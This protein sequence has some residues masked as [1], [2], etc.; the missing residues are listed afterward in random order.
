[1]SV[2]IHSEVV[3]LDTL[4]PRPED[5]EREDKDVESLIPWV[6]RDSSIAEGDCGF[7]WPYEE[8]KFRGFFLSYSSYCCELSWS[9][10][11]VRNTLQ[12]SETITLPRLSWALPQREYFKHSLRSQ[13]L[14]LTTLLCNVYGSLDGIREQGPRIHFDPFGLKQTYVLG[15]KRFTGKS[16]G[17]ATTK[18]QSGSV[19]I[20]SCTGWYGSQTWNEFLTETL[21]IMLG[22]LAK[23]IFLPGDGAQVQDQEVYAVGFRGAYFHIVYGYFP[24][25]T[26]TRVHSKGCARDEKLTLRFSRGYHLNLKGDWRDAMRALARLFRYL[27]SGEAEVGA[28]KAYGRRFRH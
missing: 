16:E 15:G 5:T 19:P 21:S 23:N 20:I 10:T 11:A 6:F 22:Q 25:G 4:I 26:I 12:T 3:D 18:L 13:G 8:H 14:M 27:V 7:D 1:M 9:S 24:A 17:V 2:T 28:T